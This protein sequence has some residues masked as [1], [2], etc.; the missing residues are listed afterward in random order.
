[1]SDTKKFP[2]FKAPDVAALIDPA[3]GPAVAPNQELIDMFQS[4][5]LN[6]AYRQGIVIAT[7]PQGGLML[8]LTRGLVGNPNNL[9][10][11]LGQI[12]QAKAIILSVI[13]SM[14]RAPAAE[15]GK[16]A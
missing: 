2:K 1:M 16:D 13:Q 7:D 4:I 9:W 5:T 14:T 11:A 10:A 15:E 8:N 12:E 6:P 3:A